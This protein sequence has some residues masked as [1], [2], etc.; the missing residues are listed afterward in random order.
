M[1]NQETPQ[2]KIRNPHF[3]QIVV[4]VITT[5]G[6]LGTA[7]IGNWDKIF[8]GKSNSVIATTAKGPVTSKDGQTTEDAGEQQQVGAVDITG[9]WKTRVITSPYAKNTFY[10]LVFQFEMVGDR[11]FGTVKSIDRQSGRESILGIKEGRVE[12]NFVTFITESAVFYGEDLIPYQTEYHGIV[13]QK[14]IEFI[15][16]N[17]APGGGLPEKLGSDFAKRW[18]DN[19]V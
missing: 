8:P 1:A 19:W 11:L 12:G 16:Q 15:R 9:V 5:L 6:I 7:I 17:N 10:S 3:T 14:L 18:L 13:Q 2:K 4:A